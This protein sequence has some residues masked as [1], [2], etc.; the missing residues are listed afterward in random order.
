[1]LGLFAHFEQYN[2]VIQQYSRNV[3]AIFL[4]LCLALG[5]AGWRH[6]FAFLNLSVI[7]QLGIIPI[8]TKP[9]KVSTTGTVVVIYSTVA[10]LSH[11]YK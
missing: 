8:H 5:V 2:L 1:M 6:A 9:G 7:C 4:N 11:L 3:L 10:T